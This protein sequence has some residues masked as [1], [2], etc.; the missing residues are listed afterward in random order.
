MFNYM[1]LF[2]LKH[3]LSKISVQ[4][5]NTVDYESFMDSFQRTDVEVSKKWLENMLKEVKSTSPGSKAKISPLSYEMFEDQISEMIKVK[6]KK[7][8][9]VCFL[10]HCS[11]LNSVSTNSVK[12]RAT[13]WVF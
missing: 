8:V 5:D 10:K 9:K 3:L 1:V 13:C 6:Q 12:A 11:N 7:I 2:I 4:L